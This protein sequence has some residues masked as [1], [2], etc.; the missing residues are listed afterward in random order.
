MNIFVIGSTGFIGGAL[1]RHFRAAGHE[2]TGLARSA[3]A[4]ARLEA[5]GI[6]PL[7]GDLDDGLP[8]AIAAAKR[9]DATIFA[10]QVAP[11]VE[12]AAVSALLDAIAGQD[13]SFLFTSGTGVFLQRTEGAWSEDSFTEDDDFTV[14][15]L[16]TRRMEVETMVRA[17]TAR[18]IRGIAIRPPLI[19]GPGDHGHV[20][21][22]Y[23]SVAATG[24]ACYVGDG[25]ACYSNVHIDDVARLFELA[26]DK[27]RPGAVYH[28]VGGETPNRWI[29][30][31]V[32]RDL[33]CDTRSVTMAEAEA[34]WGPFGALI[35]SASSR[36][37]APRSRAELGWSPTQHDMLAMIGEPRFR[38]LAAR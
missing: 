25:L 8:V 38:A 26:L 27:G 16:A 1:A 12:H 30:E 28:G 34:I 35:M 13:K 36:A 37:R 11:D 2:V 10:A 29:A 5:D 17:A 23:M 9:A 4:A 32:A 14:E 31:A 6:A 33:G 3:G 19:W 7:I 18:G 24:S 20:L 22:T 15:P 21:L